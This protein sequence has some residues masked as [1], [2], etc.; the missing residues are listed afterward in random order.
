[1]HNCNV[2]SKRHMFRSS[3][4]KHAWSKTQKATVTKRPTALAPAHSS[5]QDPFALEPISMDVEY[6]H[7]E[8]ADGSQLSLA[9]W[10]CVVS[11]SKPLFKTYV[12]HPALDQDSHEI[13]RS[14]GGVRLARLGGA[15]CLEAVRE[16]GKHP[17][18][19]H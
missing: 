8:R 11:C 13:L 18:P 1:M 17:L 14:Y 3:S 12:R 2:L 19:Y 15:P 7:L 6:A 9:A 5:Q 4:L 10:V 16:K